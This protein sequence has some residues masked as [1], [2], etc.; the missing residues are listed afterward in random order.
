MG[1]FSF[2]LEIS[3]SPDDRKFSEP[4]FVM[5]GMRIIDFEGWASL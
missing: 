5:L 4:P 2:T 3:N 1:T